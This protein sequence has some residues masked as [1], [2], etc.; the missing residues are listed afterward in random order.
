ML[1]VWASSG[2][3][4]GVGVENRNRGPESPPPA[5]SC[6]VRIPY[7]LVFL[8]RV[9]TPHEKRHVPTDFSSWSQPIFLLTPC[10]R[11]GTALVPACVR[12]KNVGMKECAVLQRTFVSARATKD[13][14]MV[15]AEHGDEGH[16]KAEHGRY[17]T[18]S[19]RARGWR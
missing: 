17:P 10:T 14:G 19:T 9:I 6:I 13:A 1:C 3:M 8:E 2:R 5:L 12:Q 18:H 16:R 11:R 4:A 15:D 7:P